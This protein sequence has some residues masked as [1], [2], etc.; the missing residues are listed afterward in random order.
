MGHSN[1]KGHWEPKQENDKNGTRERRKNCERYPDNIAWLSWLG[2]NWFPP[3]LTVRCQ[4]NYI[5]PVPSNKQWNLI[6]FST[7][8][9]EIFCTPK[10]KRFANFHLPP[11]IKTVLSNIYVIPT[12]FLLFLHPPLYH[13]D[14]MNSHELPTK[15]KSYWKTITIH[16]SLNGKFCRMT[17]KRQQQQSLTMRENK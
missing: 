11:Q 10:K 6:E 5:W 3:S 8:N 13:R 15:C 17:N 12:D 1:G 16:I 4:I 14:S 2:I 7:K 9:H